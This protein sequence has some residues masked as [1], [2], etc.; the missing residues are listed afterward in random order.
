V[1]R[2]QDL[3]DRGVTVCPPDFPD[4]G[5]L[6]PSGSPDHDPDGSDLR[7]SRPALSR[8]PT[9]RYGHGLGPPALTGGDDLALTS[10]QD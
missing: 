7:G 10:P 9:W 2:T 3:A 5:S 8:V 4:P 1:A 6:P